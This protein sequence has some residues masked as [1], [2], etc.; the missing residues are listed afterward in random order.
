MAEVK[1][2]PFDLSSPRTSGGYIHIETMVGIAWRKLGAEHTS[3]TRGKSVSRNVSFKLQEA[4][5]VFIPSSA[6]DLGNLMTLVNRYSDYVMLT[7]K[8]VVVRMACDDVLAV[9]RRYVNVSDPRHQPQSI[10]TIHLKQG[11]FQATV[12]SN[13]TIRFMKTEPPRTRRSG[14]V[15]LYSKI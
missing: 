8:G 9:Y 1:V 13:G 10:A 3:T 5:E 2:T 12:R 11:E 14:L 4:A 15:N 6:D 7:D